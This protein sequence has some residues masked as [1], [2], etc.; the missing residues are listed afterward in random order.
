MSG[1]LKKIP[2]KQSTSSACYVAFYAY[3]R[4]Q[5]EIKNLNAINLTVKLI[6][7]I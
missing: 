7:W 6:E 5:S 2:G 4:R 3:M 1:D